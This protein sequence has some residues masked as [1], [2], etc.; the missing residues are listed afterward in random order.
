MLPSSRCN[1]IAILRAKVI[2]IE[3]HTKNRH[4]HALSLL[5]R[6]ILALRYR[7]IDER[8]FLSFTLP[9]VDMCGDDT[10]SSLLRLP[11]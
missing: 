4:F 5:E 6:L 2:P 7:I 8:K 11:D 3:E 10:V 1:C 9:T